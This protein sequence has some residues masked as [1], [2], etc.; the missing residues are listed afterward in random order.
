MIFKL[1]GHGGA[2]LSLFTDGG[3]SRPG[4]RDLAIGRT[5]IPETGGGMTGREARPVSRAVRLSPSASVRDEARRQAKAM[6]VPFGPG[7]RRR[8]RESD[9]CDPHSWGGAR[10][11]SRARAVGFLRGSVRDADMDSWEAT[12]RVVG[13]SPMTCA[14][15][16]RSPVGDH[17]GL[18]RG[19]GAHAEREQLLRS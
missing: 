12:P 9:P 13:A 15:P 7:P 19:R 2:L 17:K 8:V 10:R 14:G 4:G 5:G 1:P 16:G 11:P 18:A 3:V 6:R